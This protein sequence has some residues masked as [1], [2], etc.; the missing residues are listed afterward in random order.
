MQAGI[1]ILKLKGK[2]YRLVCPF[3]AGFQ[4]AVIFPTLCEELGVYLMSVSI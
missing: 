4:R 3:A 1:A 2:E